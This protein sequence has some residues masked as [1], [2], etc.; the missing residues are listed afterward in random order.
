MGDY[1]KNSNLALAV[2]W[3]AAMLAGCTG[4]GGGHH[5]GGGAGGGEGGGGGGVPGGTVTIIEP[6]AGISPQVAAG[7]QL[8]LAAKVSGSNGSPISW[9]V[10]AGDTCTANNGMSSLGTAGGTMTLGTLPLSSSDKSVIS[11][12]APATPP[13]GVGALTVTALQSPSTT[14]PCVV[15]YVVASAD[16]LLNFSYVFA[17]NGFS[18]AAGLPFA[19]V[20]RFLA[21]GNGHIA[22][23]LEDVNI[24]QSDGSSVAF[25]KVAFTGSYN[26]DSSGHGTMTLTMTSPPWAGSPPANPPPAMMTFS[27]TLSLD[28]SFGD[29]IETDGAA[30]SGYVGSGYY[31]FQG[32]P[33]KF[34]TQ[35]IAGNYLLFLAGTAGPRASAVAKGL[36][37]RL[38]LG[39]STATTGT[40]AN[41]SLADDQS[42]APTQAL[43]G[44]YLIDDQTNGHGALNI[45]GGANRTVSFYIAT[46]GK[47]VAL[48]TDNSA[49]SA[50]PDGIVSGVVRFMPQTTFDNTSLQSAFFELLG[51]NGGHS[52]AALG[53]FASGAQMGSTT[54]GFLQGIIDLNDAGVV[55]A[56]LPLSFPN[57]ASY[58]VAPNGRGTIS[59]SLGAVTYHFVF[60]LRKNGVG[61]LLEQPASDASSR[62]RTGVFFPQNVTTTAGGT[63]M[64]GTAVTTAG[65]E[66]AVAVLSLT[67]ANHAATFQNAPTYTS[68]LGSVAQSGGISGTFSL[69]D[70]ANNRG[71]LAL[72]SGRLAG[73][74]TAVFYIT[75]DSE[76]VV[77]GTD[78]SNVEPQLIAFDE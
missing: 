30:G 11:Y 72:S 49:A 25:T 77:L 63:F 65:S 28:G 76:V 21:D 44:G 39:A 66:N 8:N 37:G 69:T 9:G 46:P 55:P 22:S 6:A 73:S 32:S 52:S 56:N 31:Q 48:R 3:A 20:G 61:F 68:I 19:V 47:L 13:A 17:L 33:A 75:S 40:I 16:A 64:G 12:T 34:N 74:G 2:V 58:T 54:N 18:T 45:T 4:G 27:F 23:G 70:Q 29:L 41:T 14:G 53:V 57:G 59:L 71:S 35:N 7:T 43:T 38:D 78:P 42:G 15:L 1:M 50:D 26:M 51:M 36:L 10:Q 24:A 67:V 60:Y 5:G 62:A